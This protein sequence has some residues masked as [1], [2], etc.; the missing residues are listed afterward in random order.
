MCAV[1]TVEEPEPTLLVTSG[2]RAVAQNHQRGN[3]AGLQLRIRLG[4]QSVASHAKQYA[5]GLL[6]KESS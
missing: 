5:P 4:I 6:Q 2:Y 3:G 1:Q